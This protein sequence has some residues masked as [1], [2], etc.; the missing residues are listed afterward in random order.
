MTEIRVVLADDH[1]IVRKG[2]SALLRAAAIDVVGEAGD[3]SELVR[4][5]RDLRPDVA[6]VDL[7]MPRLDGLEAVRRIAR[8]HPET[9][10]V[11][12]SVFDDAEYRTCAQRAGAW[13]YVRKDEASDRLIDVIRRVMSGEVCLPVDG[14]AEETQLDALTP[15]EREVLQL[16]AEGRKNAEIAQMMNRSVHTVRNHR[17]RLMRKLGV[18]SGSDLV[19]VSAERGLIRLGAPPKGLTT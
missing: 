3:G 13:G 15:R 1:T 19:R 16:I 18:R 8:R 12:V 6:L 17:A 9:R 5:V 10:V 4:C 7:S 14:G 11:I 2:I